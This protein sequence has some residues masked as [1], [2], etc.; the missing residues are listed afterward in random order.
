[1]P[2]VTAPQEA[3]DRRILSEQ[4]ALVYRHQP[5]SLAM[6]AGLAGLIGLYLVLQ[7][8]RFALGM[9]VWVGGM[10]AVVLGRFWLGRRFASRES[11]AGEPAGL[12]LRGMRFGV[13]LTGLGWGIL[14]LATL[15][16]TSLEAATFLMLVLAGIG[17]GAVP[18][19]SPVRHLFYLYA[20][21]IYAPLVLALFYR[22]G[23]FYTTFG[24][25]AVMFVLMLARSARVMN[26]TLADSLRQRFAKEAALESADT[27]LAAS[28]EANQRLLAEIDQRNL[29]EA[30]LS[31]ASQ[32]AEAAS[33]A[34][35]LFLAHMSHEMRTPMNGILGMTELALETDLD[36]EQKD[37]LH[38]IHD[39]ALRLH[40]A[41]SGV[42]Q[43]VAL[44]SGKAQLNPTNVATSDLLRVVIEQG[45]ADAEAKA[46]SLDWSLADDLPPRIVV[47]VEMLQHVLRVLLDNAIK[48]TRSGGVKVR[49]QRAEDAG[50]GHRL[51]LIVEDTGIGISSDKLASLFYA[52]N[53]LETGYA[54][55]YEG[56][57]LGLALCA[58]IATALSG[59]IWA[60]S[61]PSK[62]SRFHFVFSYEAA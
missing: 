61:E 18:V 30:E 55:G 20:L 34:K 10:F 26:E 62:G 17:A 19:L 53:Q 36:E 29:V 41:I 23:V 27:A 24:L 37:Y 4:M 1:M 44:E 35:S 12:W 42:L 46:L 3:F 39:S 5:L 22:G 25:V 38:T 48:F 52:F 59:K 40:N 57:G 58:R 15:P 9:G 45:H 21:L 47:D 60:E 50:A 31:K 11:S 51:H 7:D 13:A 56:L 6:V 49:L 16:H 54:R 28:A 8:D 33:R 43:Y 2:P 14:S 32:A